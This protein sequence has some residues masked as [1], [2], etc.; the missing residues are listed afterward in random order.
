MLHPEDTVTVEASTGSTLTC[1]AYGLPL[2]DIIWLREG[3][4]IQNESADVRI[5]ETILVET[6]FSFIQS[7]LEIC[8][9]QDHEGQYSCHANNSGGNMSFPFQ[10]DVFHGMCLANHSC[11]WKSFNIY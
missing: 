1:V 8:I 5:Y 7:V 2:P 9:S 6:N 11:P 4:A 3:I 10:I